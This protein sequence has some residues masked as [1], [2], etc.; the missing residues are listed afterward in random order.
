MANGIVASDFTRI[1]MPPCLRCLVTPSGPLPAGKPPRKHDVEALRTYGE[2]TV[3]Q[4]FH[5]GLVGALFADVSLRSLATRKGVR[6]QSIQI[7]HGVSSSK[8]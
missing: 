3:K 7:T 2:I 6:M 8:G 4:Q 5:R 1:P